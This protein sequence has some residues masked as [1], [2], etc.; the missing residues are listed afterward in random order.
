MDPCHYIAPVE[1]A[2]EFNVKQVACGEEHTAL[3]SPDGKLFLMGSN[4][5]G[6][7]GLKVKRCGGNSI[8]SFSTVN[9]DEDGKTSNKYF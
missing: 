5:C 6:Q 8:E 3:L 1:A 2:L 9:D 7:I 4:S